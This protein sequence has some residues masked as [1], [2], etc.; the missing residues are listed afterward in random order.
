VKN[1]VAA[2]VAGALTL[3]VGAV[4]TLQGAGVFT[5]SPM[6]GQKQWFAIGLAAVLA[7]IALLGVGVRRRAAARKR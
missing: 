7:G 6:T 1:G 5:G 4:W 3:V 2:L